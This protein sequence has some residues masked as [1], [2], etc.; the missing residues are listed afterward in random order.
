MSMSFEKV[1]K[2]WLIVRVFF[3]TLVPDWFHK[4]ICILDLLSAQMYIFEKIISGFWKDSKESNLWNLEISIWLLE[5]R[6]K[7]R[8]NTYKSEYRYP[9]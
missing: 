3:I 5:T 9:I 8:V 6:M 1:G 4:F 2:K 7:D